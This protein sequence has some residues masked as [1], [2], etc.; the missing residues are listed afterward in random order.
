MVWVLHIRLVMHWWF[1]CFSYPHVSGLSTC[2]PAGAL[3]LDPAGRLPSPDSLVCPPLVNSWLRPCLSYPIFSCPFLSLTPRFYPIK[4]VRAV[5][6]CMCAAD[7]ER[8]GGPRLRFI[9]LSSCVTSSSELSKTLVRGAAQCGG[10]WCWIMH[11]YHRLATLHRTAA[12]RLYVY[13]VPLAASYAIVL[14]QTAGSDHVHNSRSRRRQLC[15]VDNHFR[16]ETNG[17]YCAIYV[18]HHKAN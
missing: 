4:P 9:E 16:P 15:Y 17:F 1:V 12:R 7:P 11:H 14:I 8:G 13:S 18:W 2:P 3:P 6:Y 5:Q 10:C